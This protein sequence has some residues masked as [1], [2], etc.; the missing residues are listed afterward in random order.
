[1]LSELVES[2]GLGDDGRVKVVRIVGIEE[3]V[4]DIWK[5]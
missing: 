5:S 4:Y 1:M 2:V 3:D